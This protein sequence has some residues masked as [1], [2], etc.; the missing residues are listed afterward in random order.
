LQYF[1][2][3]PEDSLLVKYH[4]N[5]EDIV[6]VI[7]QA[8]KDRRVDIIVPAQDVAWKTRNIDRDDPA[9]IIMVNPIIK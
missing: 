5:L 1:L 7:I 8:R 3:T 4:K 6:K 9:K 2:F